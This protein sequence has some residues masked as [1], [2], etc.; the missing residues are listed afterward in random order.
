MPIA[1]R[2]EMTSD[3][4]P[5]DRETG[6]PR[7]A[8]QRLSFALPP[9]RLCELNLITVF[10]SRQMNFWLVGT[11][12]ARTGHPRADCSRE[13]EGSPS[14]SS[15]ISNPSRQADVSRFGEVKLEVEARGP[16]AMTAARVLQPHG[17]KPPNPYSQRRRC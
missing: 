14:H 13:G 2:V 6:V 16:A 10:C 5:A 7:K 8:Q 9:R 17:G 15:H 1:F 12:A 3:A 4:K 11:Q